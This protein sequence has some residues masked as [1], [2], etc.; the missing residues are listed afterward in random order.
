MSRQMAGATGVGVLDREPHP[1][2]FRPYIQFILKLVRAG[3]FHQLQPRDSRRAH[4]SW[5]NSLRKWR[6]QEGVAVPGLVQ[7]TPAR[8]SGSRSCFLPPQALPLPPQDLSRA[9]SWRPWRA[10]WRSVTPDCAHGNFSRHTA[11]LRESSSTRACSLGL[12]GFVPGNQVEKIPRQSIPL[13][14]RGSLRV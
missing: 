12:V 6:R 7:Q 11:S 1:W 8:L 2:I 5:R 3:S 10:R 13:R 14:R 4:Y 9:S